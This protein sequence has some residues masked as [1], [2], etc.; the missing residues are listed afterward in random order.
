M[1]KKKYPYWLIALLQ[2]VAVLVY[3]ALV[4]WV[5]T[6]L[7][8]SF[9][10]P[11]YAGVVMMLTLLVFSAAMTGSL[12]FGYPVYLAMN[13]RTKEA[14]KVL[15]LTLLYILGLLVIIFALVAIL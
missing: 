9:T 5:M 2:A 15:G 1:F 3:V 12:V 11:A 7:G 4:A 6:S 14:V 8:K 13:K 10:P